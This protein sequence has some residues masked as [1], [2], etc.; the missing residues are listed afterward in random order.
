VVAVDR[1]MQGTARDS[2]APDG[3]PGRCRGAN[4]H[5][6]QP[7]AQARYRRLS[8]PSGV[9]LTGKVNGHR[10]IPFFGKPPDST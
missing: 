9:E 10:E 8:L 4:A 7:F 6:A 1:G 3:G 2:V 5:E